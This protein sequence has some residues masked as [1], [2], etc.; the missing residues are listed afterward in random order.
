MTILEWIHVVLGMFAIGSGVIV[1]RGLLRVALSCNRVVRFLRYSLLAS[2][3]GILPLTRHPSSIQGICML[4]VYCVGTV[5]LAW[6]KFHLAG[7]W[8]SVFAFVIVAVLYLNVVSLSIRLFNH[9]PLFAKVSA[10]SVSNFEI[11]QLC[12]AVSFAVL[13]VLAVSMCRVQRTQ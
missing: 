4:S 11:V 10:E 7:P 6:R 12:L 2:V 1:L 9:P 8:R 13:G 3:A 5:V